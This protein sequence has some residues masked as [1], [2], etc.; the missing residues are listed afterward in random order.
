MTSALMTDAPADAGDR[1]ALTLVTP[2]A[3]GAVDTTMDLLAPY[4]GRQRA[5]ILL[6]ELGPDECSDVLGRLT[7]EEIEDL[8]TEV[9]RLDAVPAEVTHAVLRL[10]GKA[11]VTSTETHGGFELARELLVNTVGLDRATSILE[12]VAATM[13]EMPFHAFHT[14]DPRQIVSILGDEHPQIMAIVLAH[15]PTALASSVL[16]AWPAALQSQVAHRIAVM[17]RTS[18]EFIRRV[19]AGLERRLSSLGMPSTLST[20]GGV[21]PLVDIINRSDRGTERLILD[22]LERID[23][24]LA[25][26]V[27]KEMFMFEDV[28]GLE[29]RAIQLVLRQV[30][31]S[32]LAPALKG[33]KDNVRQKLMQ[34]L[35][36]R[37]A[38][39]LAEE[40]DILG[41][42]R[43]ATVQ[44]A[45]AKIVAVVRDL[46]ASGQI[47]VARGDEDE[48]VA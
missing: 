44:E 20:V 29:D 43:L 19:E 24:A 12:R 7:D 11:T 3:A 22:G 45:Q 47:I 25:E 40:L 38:L 39:D 8:S 26:E 36:E 18:P 13:V 37:A 1:P 16:A 33:V 21:R 23:P 15:L 17:D 6:L 14:L 34:N 27:R 4:T 30:P 9:A 31:S 2:A 35:S 28:A 46:E 48:F 32:E 5:A 10:F 42:L 41:P